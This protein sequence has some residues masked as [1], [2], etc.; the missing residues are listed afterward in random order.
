MSHVNDS[1][2]SAASPRSR[3]DDFAKEKE[4]TLFDTER[5]AFK[6]KT[7]ERDDIDDT[8]ELDEPDPKKSVTAMN[9]QNLMKELCF[10]TKKLTDVDARKMKKELSEV[11]NAVTGN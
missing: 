9:R 8:E 3:E 2:A 4:K 10:Q 1:N 11:E 7:S 6:R 5:T